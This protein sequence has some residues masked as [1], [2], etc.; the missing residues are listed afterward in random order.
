MFLIVGL[1]HLIFLPLLICK[2]PIHI[3]QNDDSTSSLVKSQDR[4]AEEE[5][6][7]SPKIRYK[8]NSFASSE[9]NFIIESNK[10]PEISY[11]QLLKDPLIIL[12]S[13]AQFVLGSSL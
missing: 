9:D 13:I 6:K 5:I 10:E 8:P 7:T 12:P 11:Y 3:D 2:I 4:Y 1:L